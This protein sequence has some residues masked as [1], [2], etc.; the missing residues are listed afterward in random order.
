MFPNIDVLVPQVSITEEYSPK[1]RKVA[2]LKKEAAE[3]TIA[4]NHSSVMDSLSK[5]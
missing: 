2:G 4:Q 1:Y 5:L 3:A